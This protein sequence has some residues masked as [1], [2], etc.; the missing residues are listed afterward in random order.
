MEYG[1]IYSEQQFQKT[2]SF[3]YL[4]FNLPMTWLSETQASRLYL[5]VVLLNGPVIS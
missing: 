1:D 3:I 5:C 2:F 4:P